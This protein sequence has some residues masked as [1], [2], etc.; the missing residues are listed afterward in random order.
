MTEDGLVPVMIDGT[1]ILHV[2][3]ECAKRMTDY[4]MDIRDTNRERI[5][6]AVATTKKEA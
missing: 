6:R 5:T 1:T 4:W 2:C 3:K